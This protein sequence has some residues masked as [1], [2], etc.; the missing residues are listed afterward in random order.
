MTLREEH[1]LKEF[2]KRVLRRLVGPKRDGVRRGWR[3]LHNEKL[4][5]LYPST[6]IIRMI[7]QG[8]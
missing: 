2:K 4:Q 7:K 8:G 6:S 1:R 3:K 5:N